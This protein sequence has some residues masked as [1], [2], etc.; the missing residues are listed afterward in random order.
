MP[1][2]SPKKAEDILGWKPMTLE[3]G[4]ERTVL[5]MKVSIRNNA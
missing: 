3:E 2:I 4:I 5:E 1:Y